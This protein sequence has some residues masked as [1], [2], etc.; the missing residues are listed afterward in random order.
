MWDLVVIGAGS[1][2][3]VGS[4]TAAALG[5]RVLLVEA[6]RFG[7]ECL[8]TGCVPSKALIAS[9][10]AAHA[11]RSSAGLGV[12]AGEIRVDFPTVMQHVHSAI[13]VSYT[14]L[15]LPTKRIV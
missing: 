10:A 8:H 7:G 1:A 15:T 11:A 12:T 14:H 2:G 5:A 13:P 3:L 4:R 9:A 6:H